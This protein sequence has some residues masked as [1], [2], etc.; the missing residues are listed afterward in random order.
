MKLSILIRNLNE[1]DNLEKTLLAIQKQRTSFEY[2]IVILDNESE[3]GS[4][5]IAA[6]F[7]CIVHSIPRNSFTFGSALNYGINKCNAEIILIMSAHIIMLNEFFLE[8]I[9]GYFDNTSVAAL[10]FVLAD[11]PEAVTDSIENGARQLVYSNDKS[12]AYG[13]WTN[14][15]VNHCAAVKKSCCIETPFDEKI[16]SSEDKLWSMQVLKKGYTIFYNVP[17]FYVY[18]KEVQRERK[19]N[20]QIRALTAKGIISQISEWLFSVNYARSMYN[21]VKTLTRQSLQQLLI[22]YHIYKKYKR[23]KRFH[24]DLFQKFRTQV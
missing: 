16:F 4:L 14:F 2:E 1:A 9:P 7:N 8:H 12:F 3:D 5:E 19:I 23:V 11:I 6:R 10:R 17:C 21:K 20:R 13:N 15:M 24:K 18:T 22:H